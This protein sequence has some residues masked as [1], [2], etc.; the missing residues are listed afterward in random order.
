MVYEDSSCWSEVPCIQNAKFENL[1]LLSSGD[2]T[3]FYSFKMQL[4]WLF[5]VCE[6]AIGKQSGMGRDRKGAKKIVCVMERK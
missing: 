2:K 4:W 1:I 5:A 6:A 3:S